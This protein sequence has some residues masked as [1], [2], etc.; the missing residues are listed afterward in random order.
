MELK[1]AQLASEAE[2]S[3]A[4]A[5]VNAAAEKARAKEVETLRSVL[6]REKEAAGGG[7]TMNISSPMKKSSGP[8][9]DSDLE[10]KMRA[11]R[12]REEAALNA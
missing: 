5:K 8:V 4:V 9:L 2:M 1:A 11:R 12:E 3:A 6:Q 7:S 10:A